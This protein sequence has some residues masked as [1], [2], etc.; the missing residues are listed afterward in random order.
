MLYLCLSVGSWALLHPSGGTQR[1]RAGSRAAPCEC[2]QP[3]PKRPPS[4]RLV[5]STSCISADPTCAA[6][7]PLH[8]G[9]LRANEPGGAGGGG[10]LDHGVEVDLMGGWQEGQGGRGAGGQVGGQEGARAGS[11]RAGRLV[12]CSDLAS[13]PAPQA[14]SS[15]PSCA[16]APSRGRHMPQ[17]SADAPLQ[18]TVMREV[19]PALPRPTLR[20][21]AA[22]GAAHLPPLHLC[23]RGRRRGGGDGDGA[24]GAD[25]ALQGHQRRWVGRIQSGA[26]A[27]ATSGLQQGEH[28]AGKLLGHSCLLSQAM[29]RPAQLF[30]LCRQSRTTGR[31][32]DWRFPNQLSTAPC[33]CVCRRA[34]EQPHRG[35][36]GTHVDGRAGHPELR[37]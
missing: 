26:G 5:H 35:A 19:P 37:R 2:P 33:V 6:A 32:R 28:T 31:R 25:Q 14:A 8:A 29:A 7:R 34:E 18:W 30:R 9:V 27:G 21:E 1:R 23:V 24:G 22:G 10:T 36:A 16:A 3:S 13:A 11:A 17:A 15:A 20:A 4:K 12:A